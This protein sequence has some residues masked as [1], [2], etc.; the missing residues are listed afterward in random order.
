MIGT[1]VKHIANV[2]TVSGKKRVYGIFVISLTNL[3]LFS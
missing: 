1:A 3:N 2:Y